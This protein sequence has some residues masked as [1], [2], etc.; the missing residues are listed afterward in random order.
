MKK[1]LVI[2]AAMLDIVMHIDKL[3]KT[4]E[5]VYAKDQEMTVGGC[6]YNAAD[7]MRLFDVDFSLFAPLGTGSYAE[8]IKSKLNAKGHASLLKVEG[9]DNGYCLC[10]VE[11]DG[12]RTFLTL[13]GVECSFKAEWF[14]SLDAN[15]YDS[16]Y[17]SG[18]EIEGEGG[19]DI[20][21]FLE[22]NPHLDVY[23]APGPRISY[24]P[25]ELTDRI[26]ALK[27][28]VHLNEDEA[29]FFTGEDDIPKAA[30]NIF[31]KCNNNV[32]VTLGS[33]GAYVKNA[34]VSELIPSVK[35]DVKDTIGAGD[36]HIG[37][38]ISLQKLG[39][40]IKDSVKY[41]N[42]VS[43]LVVGTEG[44]TLDKEKFNKGEIINE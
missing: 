32:V 27:P 30:S 14:N 24:I 21:S 22:K 5:D 33:E 10:M 20:I 42:R 9:Q 43:A 16:A 17:I 12:E 15:E 13:P 39:Y 36:S 25:Q 44:P 2:G 8:I 19:S 41:A 34:E 18:Y 31:A 35:T 4:G 6:A 40:D 23:Y 28:I 1:C 7:I 3:P 26:F 11:S 37:A 29:K 38:F